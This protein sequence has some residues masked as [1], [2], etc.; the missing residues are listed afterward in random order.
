MRQGAADHQ[1]LRSV[2]FAAVGGVFG[3][4]SR[5]V[6]LKNLA[7]APQVAVA[8][9]QDQ[10]LRTAVRQAVDGVRAQ[11]AALGADG[12]IGLRI[13]EQ[14]SVG[15]STEVVAEGTAIRADGDVRP[16]QP[17]LSDL[18]GRDVAKLLHHGWV[19]C[20]L[21]LGMIAVVAHHQDL[22]WWDGDARRNRELPVHGNALRLAQHRARTMLRDD[23]ARLGAEGVVLGQRTVRVRTLRCQEYREPSADFL[24]TAQSQ[25]ESERQ[26]VYVEAL[27][28]GTAITRFQ[29]ASRPPLTIMPLHRGGSR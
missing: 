12:V 8:L 23:C 16:P 29:R 20:G 26:D 9:A 15:K 2:G 3:N 21:V 6:T 4:H 11:C 27:L 22:P 28:T 19:P 25:V 1:A 24:A 7:C 14:E 5:R 18:S 17:F 10:G 13:T